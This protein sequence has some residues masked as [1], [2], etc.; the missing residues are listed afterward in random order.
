MSPVRQADYGDSLA[1]K[2]MEVDDQPRWHQRQNSESSESQ[3][4]VTMS[5]VENH[6]GST[7]A[8]RSLQMSSLWNKSWNAQKE[9][10]ASSQ[11]P[12][13]KTT[14]QWSQTRAL[15]I[16]EG[17][18]NSKLIKISTKIMA[19]WLLASWSWPCSRTWKKIHRRIASENSGPDLNPRE[20]P[21]NDLKGAVH[22]RQQSNV[23][24]LKQSWSEDPKIKKILA[25][26][27]YKEGLINYRLQTFSYFFRPAC[28]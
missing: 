26:S 17:K 14:P 13:T 16:T 25:W 6:R 19:G 4:Y 15:S 10:S 5:K 20:T 2:L 11:L 24:E 27:H 21:Y 28:V 3:I 22:S 1:V 9:Y 18:L 12:S 7:A 23:S 8:T